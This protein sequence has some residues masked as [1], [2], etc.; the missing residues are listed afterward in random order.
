MK[1]PYAA[2]AARVA[3]WQA[4]RLVELRAGVASD[5]DEYVRTFAEERP[6][7]DHF[8]LWTRSTGDGY[9]V[10]AWHRTMD[11]H[12]RYVAIY[13]VPGGW[14]CYAPPVGVP[15]VT[16]GPEGWGE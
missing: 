7:R 5:A 12:R 8:D 15:V 11:G 13:G 3:A 9:P 1:D 10:A 2:E 4:A 16:D 14:W 6:E